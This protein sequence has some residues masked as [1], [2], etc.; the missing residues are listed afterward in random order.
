MRHAHLIF[1]LSAGLAFQTHA[2]TADSRPAIA[3]A[4]IAALFDR[5]NAALQTGKPD[6]VVATYAGKS[7][8]LAAGSSTPHLTP[9]E[10]IAYY[11]QFLE[12]KPVVRID[13]RQ[14]DIDGDSALDAGTYTVKFADGA[15]FGAGYSF[16]YQRFDGRWLIVSH[17]FSVLQP[18]VP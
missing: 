5:W 13:S 8:L 1:L 4:D 2:G 10:K 6:Q 3:T 9:K 7:V 17:R 16:A 15:H 12:R 14:I 11:T 18:A